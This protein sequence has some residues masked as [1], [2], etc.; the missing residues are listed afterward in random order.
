MNKTLSAALLFAWIL[1]SC[2]PAPTQVPA[3]PAPTQT[4]TSAP[5]STPSPAP[6]ATSTPAPT[7]TPA[8]LSLEYNRKLLSALP[9]S[10]QSCLPDK[11]ADDLG[12]Y[13]YDL[14]QNRELVSINADVPFQFAS[15]FKAPVLVYFLTQCKKFWDP[16]S[17]AWQAYF[18]DLEAA[19]GV[20]Y[21]ASPEYRAAI[22]PFFEDVNLWQNPDVFFNEKRFINA[23]GLAE[24]IDKRY[25]VLSKVYSMTA[26]SN[27]Q[28]TGEIL[29]WAYEQCPPEEESAPPYACYE[30]NPI[31]RFNAWFNQFAGISYAENEP[32]RGLFRW[33]TVI[34]KD[35]KGNSYEARM[36]TYGF[37]DKCAIQTARLN[38]SA[39]TGL[40]V[41]TARDFF[42]FYQALYRMDDSRVRAAALNLLAIDAEGPARGGL[43][44][45][46]RKMGAV[47]MS[48]NGHAHFILGSIN[49]DAGIFYY[50]NTPFVVVVLGYDAQPSLSALYGD[51]DSK[52]APL[53][54]KSL[55]E[56]LLNEY[57]GE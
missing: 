20:P 3:S 35:A 50:K 7:L 26:R 9:A 25:F 49:T 51:Y 5:S 15:A 37:E 1:A 2:A 29:K 38:C 41:W 33:D 8:P 6:T 30:P 56:D 14:A 17:P 13:V 24:A 4:A 10:E 47:S 16:D 54:P 21:Y 18:S 11:T 28:A 55:L 27:N 31:S 36:P 43:K 42:K 44:N 19:R 12:I 53:I 57:L 45:L 46:A 32:Q 52:G 23:G 22:A 39:S 48:K 34:E 40:N